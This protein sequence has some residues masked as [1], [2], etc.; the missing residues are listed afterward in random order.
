MHD[1]P[2]RPLSSITC[3]EVSSQ[4][5]QTQSE[6]QEQPAL[7]HEDK[8]AVKSALQLWEETEAALRTHSSIGTSVTGSEQPLLNGGHHTRTASTVS[9][10]GS[11]S[12]LTGPPSTAPGQQPNDSV[13]HPAPAVPHAPQSDSYPAHR[14]QPL[15]SIASACACSRVLS[16]R[17]QHVTHMQSMR[18]CCMHCS[19]ELEVSGVHRAAYD[20]DAEMVVALLRDIPPEQQLAYDPQGHTVCPCSRCSCR[21]S[22]PR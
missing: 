16:C 17:R 21:C 7:S 15:C 22:M 19:A 4:D 5:H 11:A 1:T 20:G 3:A 9:T 6:S 13:S 14:C 8:L 12:T 10:D 2:V 18:G